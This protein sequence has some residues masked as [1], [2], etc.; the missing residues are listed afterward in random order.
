MKM[1]GYQHSTLLCCQAKGSAGSL[2]MFSRG[3][4]VDGGENE[5]LGVKVFS[6]GGGRT[7]SCSV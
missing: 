4:A 7:W 3:M 1:L 6:Q 5:E 2:M